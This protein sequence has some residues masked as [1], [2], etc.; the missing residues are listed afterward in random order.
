MKVYDAVISRRSIRI[1][2]E[3]LV[4]YSILERCI[5]AARLAPTAMN[6]QLCE[7]VIVDDKQLLAGILNSVV[8]WGGV[9]KPAGGW[10]PEKKPL[11][12]IVVLVNLEL[13]KERGCGRS[14]AF[15]DV[16]IA[17]ENMVLVA[18]EQGVAT[19]IMTGIDKKKV[20][21]I[22]NAPAKYEVAAMLALGYPDEKVVLETADESVKRWVD[23]EGVRHVPKR[24]LEDILHRNRFE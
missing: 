11:A 21:E 8:L 24:K 6:S 3:K 22:I 17:L 1:F 13:E 5:D 20:G 2:K 15:I 10:S 14:N 18:L 4:D 12:Y 23:A 7:Y 19:C 9:S 16:G